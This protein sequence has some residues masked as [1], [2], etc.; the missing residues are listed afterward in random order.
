VLER[1]LTASWNSVADNLERPMLVAALAGIVALI[2]GRRRVAGWLRPH[3]AAAAGFVG[4]LVG[5]AVGTISNDS[6]ATI[7]IISMI[8]VGGF[9]A[10]AW[11]AGERGRPRSD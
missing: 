7:L 10:L 8:L 3:P 6:S 1:R 4:A 11:A 2:A 9:A 5:T